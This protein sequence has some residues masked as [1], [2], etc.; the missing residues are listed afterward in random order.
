[1]S[2]L[3]IMN[4]N[5]YSQTTPSYSPIPS[6]VFCPSCN[7]TNNGGCTTGLCNQ[8]FEFYT[9]KYYDFIIDCSF[10]NNYLCFCEWDRLSNVNAD[11]HGGSPTLFHWDFGNSHSEPGVPDNFFGTQADNTYINNSSGYM[12]IRLY[13]PNN[14]RDYLMF[15]NGYMMTAGNTYQISFYVSL[16]EISTLATSIQMYVGPSLPNFQSGLAT[17]INMTFPPYHYRTSPIITNYS[18]WTY[19]TFTYAATTTGLHQIYLGNFRS[20]LTTPV[21]LSN[22]PVLPGVGKLNNFC[23]MYIDDFNITLISTQQEELCCNF[24]HIVGD[25]SDMPNFG[26]IPND[27]LSN[28]NI[29]PGDKVLI[30]SYAAITQNAVYD[31]VNFLFSPNALLLIDNGVNLTFNNCHFSGCYAMWEGIQAFSGN[32]SFTFNN[33]EFEDMLG[34][35]MLT[36]G[37]PLTL[38]NC[39]FENNRVSLHLT[40][41]NGT[42]PLTMRAN[43]FRQQGNFKPFVWPYNSPV[44]YDYYP[45]PEV[46]I[47]VQNVNWVNI[48]AQPGNNN[49]NQFSNSI[50]GIF[51]ENSGLTVSNALFRQITYL[52]QSGQFYGG[53]VGTTGWAIKATAPATVLRGIKV[54]NQLGN[55][56]IQQ[57]DNGIEINGGYYSEITNNSFFNLKSTAIYQRNTP[58]WNNPTYQIQIKNNQIQMVTVGI[59]LFNNGNTLT[60][61]KENIIQNAMYRDKSV[62]I[63]AQNLLIKPRKCKFEPNGL[64]NIENNYTFRFETG[65]QADLC[66]CL[67]ISDNEVNLA[68]PGWDQ[69]HGI[70]V[71]SSLGAL[72]D[73][74]QVTG[75]GM[76]WYSQGIRLEFS[77]QTTI[78]CNLVTNTENA[79]WIHN[80]NIFSFIIGNTLQ[81]YKNGL[82]LTYNGLIGSQFIS[83]TQKYDLF[84]SFDLNP[85][86]TDAD[87]YTSLSTNGT[88]SP[89]ASFQYLN[90]YSNND[91][92]SLAISL[93]A[94]NNNSYYSYC[95]INN[96]PNTISTFNFLGPYRQ[97]NRWINKWKHKEFFMSLGDSLTVEFPHISYITQMNDSIAFTQINQLYAADSLIFNKQWNEATLLLQEITSSEPIEEFWK[98]AHQ[99]M[100]KYLPTLMHGNDTIINEVDSTS[101]YAMANQCPYKY[102]DAVIQ[103]RIFILRYIF[104]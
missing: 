40:N 38:N 44:S 50:V 70:W 62:A 11:Y 45:Q 97:E 83:G 23:Y 18:G 82:H 10:L 58:P 89:L 57:C 55:V 56:R 5:I 34:G 28:Y 42:W 94:A 13:A 67:K 73:E 74:N 52:P 30:Q 32:V 102:G 24:D 90:I 100:L 19:V 85:M 54:N 4:Y 63:R 47:K 22:A 75:S 41:Y 9:N 86:G 14:N 69:A 88:N 92:Q 79:L 60:L 96:I 46:H 78:S 15:R 51:A 65:I 49:R 80:N 99:L 77:P 59:D 26:G 61:V 27:T 8:S 6:A 103:A 48:V 33:C 72:I 31:N 93:I 25:S 3:W 84:N 71:K 20:N 12:G 37:A 68:N 101:L 21:T 53:S 66:N 81:Q 43:V 17:N 91:P 39:R 104:H 87:L 2:L 98:N 64:L 35:L 1:M 7:A 95:R 36:G 76:D 16:A 29:V